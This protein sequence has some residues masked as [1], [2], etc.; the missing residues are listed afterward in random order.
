[1][2]GCRTSLLLAALIST[3]ACGGGAAA[4][5]TPDGAPAAAICDDSAR[6]GDYCGGDKVSDA[7]ADTLYTCDGPGA[8]TAS[9]PCQRGCL[10]APPGQDDFCIGTGAY[11]L[12]WTAGVDMRLT[13]DCDDSCCSDHVGNDAYAWDWANG[14][15]FVVRA[16]RAG[17]I[18]HMKLV[19]DRGGADASN[20]HYV[21][22]IVVDHGDGTQ[23]IYMH[24]AHDSAKAGVRCG[25]HVDQGQALAMSGT[26]GHS[27]GV[28][29]HFQ[30][31]KVHQGVATCECGAD[32]LQCAADW[33][34]FPSVW[35]SST[36]P[37]VPIKV[38]EWPTASQCADRRI[39]MPTSLNGSSSR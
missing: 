5:A 38:P 21:N 32:G 39:T 24:L 3:S 35:V 37:T 29:L 1:M 16:A 17:T 26:T 20:S 4:D 2:H 10:V 7:D 30:V 8:P 13:Q 15:S 25:G 23:A 36:Y 18:T 27:T 6:T 22:M 19:S 28:H 33:N 14:K 11:H 12:P 31:S 9:S 34:P